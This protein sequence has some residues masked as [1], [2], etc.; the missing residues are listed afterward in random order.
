MSWFLKLL[1]FLPSTLQIVLI[2]YNLQKNIFIKAH[3]YIFCSE[4]KDNSDF[5]ISI[6]EGM[7]FY[8][9]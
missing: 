1:L 5:T 9:L 8:Q 4:E 7:K 6:L 2:K 3:I